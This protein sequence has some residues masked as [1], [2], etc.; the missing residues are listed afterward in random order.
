[1]TL[2]PTTLKGALWLAALQQV[3]IASANL[4][5][6]RMFSYREHLKRV[7]GHVA[8]VFVV[9]NLYIMLTVLG[10]AGLC[11]FGTDA[12]LAGDP[13]ARGLAAFLSLFWGVRL[14]FQLFF[15]DRA[16]RA[17]YRGLDAL[18]SITFAYLTALFGYL[19]V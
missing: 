7:P 12:F 3:L 17:K 15:Y 16:M 11:V 9:Q 13:L 19:A 2:E 14:A 10:M 5:A 6:V 4:F 1:M 18:F 8:E